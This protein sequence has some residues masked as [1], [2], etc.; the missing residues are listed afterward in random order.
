MP[1]NATARPNLKTFVIEGPPGML[2]LLIRGPHTRHSAGRYCVYKE[3]PPYKGTRQFEEL[4]IGV[5]DRKAANVIA[6][7]YR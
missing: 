1:I 7:L 2:D 6:E 3:V 5:R 4:A